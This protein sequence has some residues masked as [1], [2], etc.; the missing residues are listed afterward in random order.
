MATCSPHYSRTL[1]PDSGNSRSD[2]R[3]LAAL[4]A[5]KHVASLD[6]DHAR[7]LNQAGFGKSDVSL[8][9]RLARMSADAVRRSPALRNEVLRLAGK[10]RRQVPGGLAYAAGLT[11]QMAL[12]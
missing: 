2:G 8:G 6:P 9:H 11:D 7:S 1:N 5:L 3:V 10:Y 12:L 4:A